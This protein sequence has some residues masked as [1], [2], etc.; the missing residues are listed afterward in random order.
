MTNEDSQVPVNG[1]VENVAIQSLR[2]IHST[3]S[4]S[5]IAVTEDSTDSDCRRFFRAKEDPSQGISINIRGIKERSGEAATILEGTLIFKFIAEFKEFKSG[6]YV[7]HWHVKLLEGFSLL[8]GLRFS[9]G[10]SYD[11]ELEDTSGSFD[12]VSMSSE[13]LGKLVKNHPYD[14]ELEELVVI[15]PHE[16]KAT[17]ELLLSNIESERRF[18]HSGLQ[19]DCVEIRPFTGG[20]EGQTTGATSEVGKHIVKRAVNSKFE[21]EI[22]GAPRFWIVKPKEELSA[23]P[24]TRLAWSKDSS[25]LASLALEDRCA[26]ITVW[27]MNYTKDLPES[28]DTSAL[29]LTCIAATVP[30]DGL[31]DLRN[32]SIGLTI[33]PTGDQV[34]VYQ[35]PKIGQ[36]MDG[37]KLDK[38]SFR[39]HVFN[40]PL[41][42]RSGSVA[43]T[44]DG[45]VQDEIRLEK[46]D[47]RQHK[48]FDSFIGYGTFL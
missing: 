2:D 32:L 30:Y 1:D 24:I 15:Q 46:Q 26:H 27:D 12:D 23:L 44:V 5:P 45:T 48:L 39:I 22:T 33:S 19:V 6:Y 47:I 21:S 13:E 28:G 31:D 10:V 20:N 38:C 3:Q 16:G 29:Q 40:N 14:L 35:E 36:W 37:T 41:V 9:V 17:I 43:L 4:P 11:A 7:V 18:E 25:F 8:N 42:R 34:A